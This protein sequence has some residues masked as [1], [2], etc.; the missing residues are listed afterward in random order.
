MSTRKAKRSAGKVPAPN[1]SVTPTPAELCRPY[2]HM[3]RDELEHLVG[4]SIRICA[5]LEKTCGDLIKGAAVMSKML[6]LVRANLGPKFRAIRDQAI[7]DIHLTAENAAVVLPAVNFIEVCD[8]SGR[9]QRIALAP[10]TVTIV[11]EWQFR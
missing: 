4:L 5:E 7:A 8:Q 3:S 11:S 1:I 9:T 2:S 10:V 6:A